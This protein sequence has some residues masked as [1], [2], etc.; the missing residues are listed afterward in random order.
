MRV[1]ES[2][3]KSSKWAR[4][5]RAAIASSVRRWTWAGGPARGPVHSGASMPTEANGIGADLVKRTVDVSEP[6][7]EDG[8][9]VAKDV[10]PKVE[11]EQVVG[12]VAE[13]VRMSAGP[14]PRP[15]LLRQTGADRVEFEIAEKL[16]KA[17]RI[18]ETGVE[19][20]SPIDGTH[21]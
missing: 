10:T 3:G 12:I 4:D 1:T 6:V 5:R 18:E 17:L 14:G 19:T 2:S 11:R 16:A 9:R 7:G 15:P 8:V 13:A 20:R 21:A